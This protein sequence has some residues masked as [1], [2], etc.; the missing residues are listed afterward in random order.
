MA[1]GS[2]KWNGHCADFGKRTENDE[3]DGGRREW[4]LER[5]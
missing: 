5:A 1:F 4:P 3:D 2:Q